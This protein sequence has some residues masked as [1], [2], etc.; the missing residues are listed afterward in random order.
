MEIDAYVFICYSLEKSESF[1]LKFMLL[2]N[3]PE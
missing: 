1:V 3:I 2:L